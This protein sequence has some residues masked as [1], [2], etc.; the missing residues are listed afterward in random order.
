MCPASYQNMQFWNGQSIA[1][2]LSKKLYLTE[3]HVLNEHDDEILCSLIIV[4]RVIV[5]TLS[6]NIS[7]LCAHTLLVHKLLFYASALSNEKQKIL[8]FVVNWS[9]DLWLIKHHNA[10]LFHWFFAMERA[11][12]GY[13]VACKK[14]WLILR[15]WDIY[16]CFLSVASV[17][18]K[19]PEL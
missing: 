16:H 12:I 7:R 3:L 2:K 15:A 14:C 6:K 11:P 9:V 4:E 8:I 10:L 18:L 13:P 19:I 1:F 17:L 5:E